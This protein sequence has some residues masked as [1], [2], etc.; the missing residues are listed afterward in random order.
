MVTR[1]LIAVVVLLLAS[2]STLRNDYYQDF[3]IRTSEYDKVNIVDT[4]YTLPAMVKLK[5]SSKDIVA[6]LSSEQD[7]V[8][9]EQKVL[10]KGRLSPEF[11]LGNLFLAAPS[12]YFIDLTNPKRYHYNK[13]LLLNE[14]N[15]VV[16]KFYN[17]P[18]EEEDGTGFWKNA[19][20]FN[21]SGGFKK[22]LVLID[23]KNKIYLIKEIPLLNAFSFK[24]NGYEKKEVLGFLGFGLG[25]EYY[26]KSNQYL[27]FK[28]TAALGS[29]TT[30]TKTTDYYGYI[31]DRD[32]YKT[33]F[34]S[35][36]HGHRFD[37]LHLGYGL[38]FSH[39]DWSYHDDSDG[40]EKD[41]KPSIH[42]KNNML[43]L[44]LASKFELGRK[45]DLKLQYN[46]SFY[47]LSA[48]KTWKYESYV[49][50]GVEFRIMIK[51]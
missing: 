13:G 41:L 6:T 24:P 46:P 8:K 48:G 27:S 26:Y 21:P 32:V 23:R 20:S 19:F 44:A 30:S 1:V 39:N 4:T 47:N 50:L 10:F 40:Y 15:E 9:S 38:Q 33:L 5:R 31:V 45:V 22:E 12:G 18:L 7:S 43:G 49:S 17:E 16:G 25:L 36:A 29:S 2:C 14:S 37:R 34:V 51:R 35:L 11:W 42:T 28:A 3:Y